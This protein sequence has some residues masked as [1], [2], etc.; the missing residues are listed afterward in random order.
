MLAVV[1]LAF[2]TRMPQKPKAIV[3]L[4]AGIALDIVVQA[5]LGF[6][7]LGTSGNLSNGIAWVHFLNALAIFAM[8]LMATGMVMATARM[9]PGL[10]EAAPAKAG[11]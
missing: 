3:G 9:R 4:S 7:A 6:A 8:T 2:V 1:T 5:L 11:A 10:A